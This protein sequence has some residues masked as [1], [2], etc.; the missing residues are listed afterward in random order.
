MKARKG[1]SAMKVMAAANYEQQNLVLLY[2]G[3][4]LSVNKYALVILTLSNTH[5]QIRKDSE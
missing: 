4:V 3:L 1:L 2:Q 5:R